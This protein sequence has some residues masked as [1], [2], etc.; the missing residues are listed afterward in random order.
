ME[1]NIVCGKFNEIISRNDTDNYLTEEPHKTTS[2]IR[3]LIENDF[4]GSMDCL[5][6]ALWETEEL[7]C[8]KQLD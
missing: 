8:Y 3:K 2:V 5:L 4:Q 1:N 6:K 7:I